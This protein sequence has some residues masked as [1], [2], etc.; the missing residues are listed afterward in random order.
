MTLSVAE[1]D[2]KWNRY[3][4]RNTD[5]NLLKD[6]PMDVRLYHAFA[7]GARSNKL[8]VRDIQYQKELMQDDIMCILDG[9]DDQAITNV[10]QVIVDRCNILKQKMLEE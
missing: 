2:K 4:T 3:Y 7:A 6:E 9:V 10:C 1:V 5:A 8:T